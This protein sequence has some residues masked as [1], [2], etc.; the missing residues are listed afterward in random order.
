MTLRDWPNRCWA[1]STGWIRILQKF[2]GFAC[3]QLLELSDVP[4]PDLLRLLR[5]LWCPLANC[6]AIDLVLNVPAEDMALRADGP[7]LS[8]VIEHLVKNSIEAID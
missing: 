7:K 2:T 6:R 8:R 3:G 5:D 4:V 1:P